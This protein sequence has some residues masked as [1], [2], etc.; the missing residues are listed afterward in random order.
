MSSFIKKILIIFIFFPICSSSYA[1]NKIS[2][3]DMDFILSKSNA[4]KSLLKQLENIEA[5]QFEEFK[6]KEKKFKDDENKILNSKNILSKEEYENSVN[7]FRKN[8]TNYQTNKNNIIQKLKKKR[9]N[10]IMSFIKRI[11]PLINEF[12][13]NNSIDILI[14]KKKYIYRKVKL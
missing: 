1:E 8:L 4:S 14:E 3:I 2:Y 7:N 10:E 11:N 13:K 12:M 5:A 6:I 9:N